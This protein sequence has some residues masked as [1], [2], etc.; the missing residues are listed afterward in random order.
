MSQDTIPTKDK[1]GHYSHH[2]EGNPFDIVPSTVTESVE[3]DPDSGQY[4]ISKKI[5]DEYYTMPTYMTFA[6]YL[7]WKSKKQEK[8]Y[9][10]KLAGISN[11]KKSNLEDPMTKF[12]F[13]DSLIDRLFGVKKEVDD[14][15]NEIFQSGIRIQPQGQ[16]DVT[17]Q[18]TYY[19]N[20][21]RTNNRQNSTAQFNPIDPDVKI[22][23]SVDGGIG[24][25]IDLGFNYDT[26]ST[27]DFDRKIKLAYNSES[28]G[29]DDI[30]KNIEAG[31]VS[32][33]L[34]SNL[35]QGAQS[36]FGLK[37]DL[38]FGNLTLTA[39]ASQQR[40][41][42][43]NR[44]IENGGSLQRFVITP[45]DYDENR[46]FF[47]SHYNR[48]TYER[49]LE[50]LPQINTAFRIVQLELWVSDDQP[51]YQK[52]STPVV[53]LAD[54]GE[55][56]PKDFT[57]KN[58]ATRFGPGI[59]PLDRKD[60]DFVLPEND[61]N[62]IYDFVNGN[63]NAQEL[64]KVSS[65]LKSSGFVQ[66]R[67]FEVYNGRKLN[68]NEYTFNEK[69][70]FVSLNIRLRPNQRL[71]ASYSYKYT[72]NARIDP[73]T[74]KA[75]IDLLKVGTVTE[76]QGVQTSRLA[77]NGQG[78]QTV[79]PPKVVFTKLLKGS[80]QRTDVPTWDLMMKNVYN[81]GS[82]NIS[83]EDFT[84]DIFFE[85]DVAEGYQAGSL[86]K[87]I[88]Q[89]ELINRPLLQGLGLDRLN[90]YG[91][92]QPDGIFDFVPGVTIIPRTGTIVFPFLQ[93]FGSGLDKLAE[94]TGI[95]PNQ[96][97]YQ[98][99]YDTSITAA[100]QNQQYNKFR[101]V[102]E[103]K[104]ATSGEIYLGAFVPRGSVRVRAGGVQLVEGQDYEINYSM[105]RLTITNDAYLQMGTP[106][107][108]SFEDQSLFSLQQKTMLGL[109]AD[110]QVNRNFAVGGTYLHLKERPFSQKVNIGN[111]PISNR[112]VGLDMTYSAEA[113]WV[114]KAVDAL[115]LF[116][117]KEKS[118]INFTAEGAYLIPGHPKIINVGED[119]G[120]VS[121]DDFES[122]ISGI[123]LGGFNSNQWS[124]A[125]TP[126]VY[127]ESEKRNNLL[128]GA[129]RALINWYV[130]DRTATTEDDKKNPYTRV[131]LQ[132]E[133]FSR[134]QRVG[135]NDLSTFDISYFP[136]ERGPY[137]FDLPSGTAYSAGVEYDNGL[138]LKNPASR[139]GGIQ[140]YFQN[141]DFEASN[142]EFIEF[143][144]LNPFMDRPDG[145]SHNLGEE[146]EIIFNL[147]N[148]SEDIIKDGLQ[149]FENSLPIDEK[150]LVTVESTN[151]GKVPVTIP[152]ADGFDTQN[153]DK[154][155]L[156][157]N[158]L[159]DE[160]ERVKYQDYLQALSNAGFPSDPAILQDPANDNYEYNR[161]KEGTIVTRYKKFN[162][163]QGN[164][165]IG[166]NSN[167]SASLGNRF[168][169][170]EDLNKNKSLD[171]SEGY[172]A[173]KVKVANKNNE[174]DL[175]KAARYIS[176]TKKITNREGV[177]E[178][179]YRFR[180][181]I[182]DYDKDLTV[183]PPSL[184]SIQFMRMYFTG[185][186]T[187]KIFRLAE[188]QIVRNSWRKRIECFD[189]R[190]DAD[191]SVDEVG[192]EEN[193]SKTPFGYKSP[194]NVNREIQ[195]DALANILQ[196]EKSMV[197]RFCDLSNADCGLGVTK[198]QN[199][200][201][202]MYKRLQLLTHAEAKEGTTIQD[203][204]LSVYVR[205]GKDL[206]SNYYEYELPLKISDVANA[207]DVKEIWKDENKIDFPLE[208]L[209]KAKVKRA[210]SKTSVTEIFTMN[211]PDNPKAKVSV[212]GTPNLGYVK[213]FEI[214]IKN[215]H[216]DSKRL[217]GEV[218]VNELRATGLNEKGG[219]AAQA[220]L[221]VQMADLGEMN[222]SGAYSSIGWGSL[223]Q[224]LLDRNR[225]E[226]LQY[227]A[228]TNLQ[229]GRF[230]GK[231]ANISIPFY[232]QYSKDIEY[233][234]F[235][236]YEGDLTVDQKVQALKA[237]N[238]DQKEIDDVKE[239]S[240]RQTEIKTF[241]FTNVK[242]QG[243]GKRP[244]SVENFSASYAYTEANT[245][246]VI[247]KEDKTRD[248]KAGIT[249]DYNVTP[250]YYR[251]FKKV[252]NKNLKLIN[253]MN[254][255]FLPN[256]LSFS[257]NVNRLLSSRVFRLPKTPVFLFDSR[258]FF[259]DR[260][261]GL[262][263]DL[264]K[265]L[266]LNFDARVSS[267]IDELRQ[268]G[269]NVNPNNRNWEDENGKDVT[270]LVTQ[271]PNYP[272]KY[273]N[274]NI[275][276]LGRNKNYNH[277]IGVA[278]DLPI[279][280]LPYMDW[281]DVNADYQATYD[282]TAGSLNLIDAENTIGN[283]IQNSQVRSLKGNLNFKKLY[284]KSG[285]L[286]K[287]LEKKRRKRATSQRKSKRKSTN[288]KQ[289]AKVKKKKDE[290]RGISGVERLAVGLLTSL[291][292]ARL[293]Y[294]ETLSTSIPGF[295]PQAELLG[296]SNGFDA[297]GFEYVI[298]LQ[299]NL[300]KYLINNQNWFNKSPVFADQILQTRDQNIDM[301]IS[302]EPIRDLKID[303]DFSKRYRR[304][305]SEEF[306][307]L[308]DEAIQGSRFVQIPLIDVGSFQVTHW[309]LSTMFDNNLD[310][311]QRFLDNRVSVSHILAKGDTR[312]HSEKNP[313]YAYGYGPEASSVIVPSFL[314][315]YT[316]V[317]TQNVTKNLQNDISKIGYLPKP[318]WNL[319]YNGLSLMESMRDVFSSITIRHGYKS[320][321]AVNR[322]FTSQE[323]LNNSSS[324]NINDNYYSEIEIPAVEINESFA[325]LLG[326]SLKTKKGLNFDLEYRKSR[327]LRLSLQELSENL[328]TEIRGGFGYV[329]RNIGKSKKDD[330]RKKRGRKS[331][332]RKKKK[333]SFI[334]RLSKVNNNRGK[335]LTINL[336]VSYR[337]DVE[338]IYKYNT[339]AP[340]QPN[341]G[342]TVLQI[343]PNVLYDINDNLTM[344]FFVNYNDRRSKATIS[345][346]RTLD[347][348]G[349]VTAQLKIN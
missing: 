109:R 55:G 323:Y 159:N 89:G 22:K 248:Y 331:K 177:E 8:E 232:A 195:S 229:L 332:P 260:N 243:T 288:G 276:D 149:F 47:L 244:W 170:T 118:S 143:W 252:R 4:I 77:S 291:K 115:P 14:E 308:F 158:G 246:D 294:R 313:D 251:P 347:I 34:K 344:R 38:K 36:L 2:S 305:H 183:N 120:V 48:N 279:K 152:V 68:P 194:P 131:V 133:L 27:F 266:A 7:E 343:M 157:Y 146:G 139:W 314:A 185:F 233:E 269:I 263:W 96:F 342:S 189:G 111:D 75:K 173:Y 97:K 311:Y 161:S 261:Y 113:P 11:G 218:W 290:A 217:C 250:K 171:D 44:R 88:P 125:S 94:G 230:F 59:I 226:L 219:Y 203:D 50:N 334:N 198:V 215:K 222:F 92:P 187:P 53:A 128:Y 6:E 37:T 91:D 245:T 293:N 103:V 24:E 20:F 299:P 71:S 200:D 239:R 322:F 46:H 268:T 262:D 141:T 284:A 15:G 236:P 19:N 64:D 72:S 301:R 249:Y 242:K 235:D 287:A 52:N 41:Q 144:V 326:I 151:W 340:P 93:P 216:G 98:S 66:D 114:T 82:N 271:N 106:I 79:E 117:T 345:I 337:D 346:P 123:F 18:S 134:P 148:V 223:D 3:Y 315:A 213:I 317:S 124:L 329:I 214:G 228:A 1:Y 306:R 188:F 163:P 204:S 267:V 102:A 255:N 207:T 292:S 348:R 140:R 247:L 176:Q 312:I 192:V 84:F 296:L 45:V 10:D 104:S 325:P 285:Y 282:W 179:W 21:L 130:L 256:T 327:R 321:L 277:N 86:L 264:T 33:P 330:K 26:Q 119:G 13:S 150:N 280:Y 259:W 225:K 28:S 231:K 283:I 341:S 63:K 61:V 286:K 164:A 181:P 328:S 101:M 224:S 234:Q 303:V 42:P 56:N 336:D 278:Y 339:D 9:F 240:K 162:N 202:N 122:S 155:D 205:F 105:G 31:N 302:L 65:F 138:K 25:K 273:R 319:R 193:S 81:L 254:F 265:S 309:G 107:N 199:I 129:N 174:I 304:D 121:I 253:E 51:S 209:K 87:Y 153:G 116:S 182:S 60:G 186:E 132:Q 196:D 237:S 135:Q 136:N 324:F 83:P 318:N 29:E 270:T 32:L 201:L 206:A 208:L 5:G 156:G 220:R 80:Q 349:G 39:I 258:R 73:N 154:Q 167:R 221:Q 145:S 180:I 76:T 335:T 12:E 62:K 169:D 197:L 142:F 85:N 307:Y 49:N 23:M 99:L 168:P 320:T 165:P 160:E 147:G 16:V 289:V 100:K 58:T 281:V 238:A 127:P 297:P 227:D 95:D 54:L 275:R 295:M 40:S 190:L 257:T 274:D 338:F 211:D 310:T 300:D 172:F 57:G 178:I 272:R 212:R 298:G 166:A 175:D 74:S 69:L 110:Y 108:V 126:S 90:E 184:R 137:N 316:G 78:Q 35:I 241:S 43:N 191:F 70:G 67:D 17:M 30:I 333:K 112:I 210:E